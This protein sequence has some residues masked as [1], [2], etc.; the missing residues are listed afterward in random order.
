M[1]DTIHKIRA[2]NRFYLPTMNLLGDHYLESEYSI[3]QIRTLFEIYENAG[4]NAAYIARLFNIDKSYLSR[5]LK[6]HE[7]NGYL[8]RERSET[9]SRSYRLYLTEAG[10]QKAETF[11]RLSNREVETVIRNLSPEERSQLTD[12]LDTVT[13]LLRKSHDRQ[14]PGTEHWK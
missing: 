9:D 4:C 12:A 1:Q 5:I 10:I 3:A 13:T 2:F 7:A 14:E 8:R 6:D 11:I